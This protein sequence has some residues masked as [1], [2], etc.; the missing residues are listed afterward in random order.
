MKTTHTITR[1]G[2]NQLSKALRAEILDDP[3]WHLNVD[4]TWRYAEGS[5]KM[6]RDL[7]ADLSPLTRRRRFKFI[8]W[9]HGDRKAP[10]L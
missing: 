8:A 3:D 1:A 2:W 5:G 4:G 9:L 7:S 10:R 6:A